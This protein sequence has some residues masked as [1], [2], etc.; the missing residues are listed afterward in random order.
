MKNVVLIVCLFVTVG[1]S[2]A[3]GQRP[4]RDGERGKRMEIMK[5]LT[6]EQRAELKTKRMTLDLD[7]T[8]GQQ[9]QVKVLLLEEEKNRPSPEERKKNKKELTSEEFYN[10]SIERLDA[11][12]AMKAKLKEILSQEQYEKFEKS[13]KQRAHQKKRAK[14]RHGRR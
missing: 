5:D 7:L 8:D 14:M 11:Q 4:E 13:Y 1:Y 2:F 9:Q 6:P 10:K 12:I 3:Q